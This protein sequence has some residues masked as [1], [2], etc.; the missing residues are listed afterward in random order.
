MTEVTQLASF[1]V[2]IEVQVAVF[3]FLTNTL[4]HAQMLP[5]AMSMSITRNICRV[6]HTGQTLWFLLRSL[7]P[8]SDLLR[9]EPALCGTIFFFFFDLLATPRNMWDLSSLTRAW[10]LHWHH[11]VLNTGLPEK[12]SVRYY[13]P[14]FKVRNVKPRDGNSLAKAQRISIWTWSHMQ[15]WTINIYIRK[16]V[17]PGSRVDSHITI[18]Y[19]GGLFCIAFKSFSQQSWNLAR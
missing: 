13:Y 1:R 19:P 17:S 4:S 11:R 3:M 9:R 8:H 12:S 18:T 15:I 16:R 14:H 10:T 6:P 7:N 5:S 2:S